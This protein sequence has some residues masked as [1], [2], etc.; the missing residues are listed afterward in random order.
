MILRIGRIGEYQVAL[1]VTIKLEIV[2]NLRLVK[3]CLIVKA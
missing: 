2:W 1:M 3:L